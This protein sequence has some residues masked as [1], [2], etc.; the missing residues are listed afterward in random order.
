MEGDEYL[1]GDGGF[2]P[3]HTCLFKLCI[4]YCAVYYLPITPQQSCGKRITTSKGC[5][6]D[7]MSFTVNKSGRG[8][9]IY[10]NAYLWKPEKWYR[11]SYLQR[12]NR[13]ANVENNHIDTKMGG[14]GVR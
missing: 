8:K 4:L 5:C 7:E 2:T 9:Q 11:S 3:I 6:L 1:D 12:R 10:I 14:E 13:N